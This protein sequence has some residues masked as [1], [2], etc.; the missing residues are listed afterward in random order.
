MEFEKSEYEYESYTPLASS[1][2][3]FCDIKDIKNQ[4]GLHSYFNII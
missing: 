4:N 1:S 2:S 3:N